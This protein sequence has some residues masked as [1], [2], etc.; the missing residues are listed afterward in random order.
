MY[1]RGN[2]GLLT[3]ACVFN[4]IA[5]GLVVISVLCGFWFDIIALAWMI[6]MCIHSQGIR[7]GKRPNTV[8]F[9]VCTL[10]FVSLIGG[11]LMLCAPKDPQ[12]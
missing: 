7:D 4:W 5:L 6:P 12:F 11:I 10:L 3:A 2:S 1:N 9:G 8:G